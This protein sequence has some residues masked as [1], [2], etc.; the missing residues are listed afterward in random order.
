MKPSTNSKKLLKDHMKFHEIKY[1]DQLQSLASHYGI[2]FNPGCF[3]EKAVLGRTVLILLF[4]VLSAAI[5]YAGRPVFVPLAV[6]GLLGMLFTPIANRVEKS[7]LGRGPAALICLLIFLA[8]VGSVIALLSWQISN[9]TEDFTQ[10]KENITQ[11]FDRFQDYLS[12][13]LGISE[14]K[15][16]KIIN[17]KTNGG[18][19]GIGA[20]ATT[21][22]GSLVVFIANAVLTLVYMLLL[23]YFRPHF[24]TFILK[25][26]PVAQQAKTKKI[27]A[28]S[29]QVVQQ[30]LSGLA[31]MVVLLWVMYG[32]GFSILG[33]KSA[34]FFAVLCGVLEIIPYIG[35]IT[36]CSLAAM[37]ALSQ[38]GGSGMV[39]GVFVTY[40]IVNLFNRTSLLP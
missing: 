39:L 11:Q 14:T 3:M 15:Q 20:M 1:P 5:L 33:I 38:G 24:R 34:L 40:A 4:V 36:G 16:D 28:Q 8:I 7:G 25:L 6:G 12:D 32:I 22:A 23:I 21:V 37:M 30:Y 9:L 10:L 31:I 27:I 2:L 18:E 26:V 19:G 35:N 17:E 13:Q 29:S